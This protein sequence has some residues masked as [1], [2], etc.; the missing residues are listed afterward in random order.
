[1][2]SPIISVI[3]VVYNGEKYLEQTIQSVCNQTYPNIEYIVIDGGSTDGTLE[4][5]KQYQSHIAYWVS[6]PDQGIYDAMNKGIQKATG[7]WLHLLNA[8]DYYYDE[9]ALTRAVAQLQSDRTNYF[10]MI[11]E[12]PEGRRRDYKF[13][14]QHWKLYISAFLPHPALIVSKQQYQQVGLYDSSLKVA[15]DHDLILRLLQVYPANDCD[16][17]LVVMRQ[18]GFSGTHLELGCWEFMQVTTRYGFPFGLAWIIY[19]L[20]LMLWLRKIL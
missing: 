2:S 15:A 5:I 8:D 10:S 14:F 6:E 17:K 7:A 16:L 13:P 19:R 4:I 3:T 12:F 1:M 18:A 9:Q 20:K 11:L